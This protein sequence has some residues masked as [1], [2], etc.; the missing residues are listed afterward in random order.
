MTRKLKRNKDVN[1]NNNIDIEEISI[2]DNMF[3][4]LNA[5]CET[6]DSIYWTLVPNEVFVLWETKPYTISKEDS[7]DSIIRTF[8][9]Q[10]F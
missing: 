10:D 2:D 3:Y 7:D 5:I 6:A 1:L 4:D 8:Y 9:R